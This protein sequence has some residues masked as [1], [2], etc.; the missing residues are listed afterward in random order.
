MNEKNKI[1]NFIKNRS[2]L[3]NG[4]YKENKIDLHSPTF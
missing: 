1:K 4:T 2:F 3:K